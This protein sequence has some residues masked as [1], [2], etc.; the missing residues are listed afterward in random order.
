MIRFIVALLLVQAFS[1]AEFP[2]LQNWISVNWTDTNLTGKI[3]GTRTV[4]DSS[5]NVVW[6]VL[7][8]PF[9]NAAQDVQC[10]FNYKCAQTTP[11]NEFSLF[12]KFV[13]FLY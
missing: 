8:G 11:G 3:D 1:C 7:C 9:K 4:S 5:G 12:G 6:F 13:E 10:N 2:D